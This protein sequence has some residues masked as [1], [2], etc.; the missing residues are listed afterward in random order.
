MVKVLDEG[1][2]LSEHTL[3]KCTADGALYNSHLVELT[4]KKDGK[5]Q[6]LA[7]EVA[8]TPPKPLEKRN[9]E[10]FGHYA[11]WFTKYSRKDARLL[12]SGA[13]R[14]ADACA[15]SDETRWV[16][17]QE[18]GQQ[19]RMGF[20]KYGWYCRVFLEE[21]GT[22]IANYFEPTG[23]KKADDAKK[24]AIAAKCG[25]KNMAFMNMYTMEVEP[26]VTF[27]DVKFAANKKKLWYLTEEEAEYVVFYIR[28]ESFK[29]Y[30]KEWVDW[31]KTY[32]LKADE[33]GLVVSTNC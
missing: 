25:E 7:V 12:S 16:V 21:D 1:A 5:T 2:D 31:V 33:C 30:A 8:H 24:A 22:I 32:S 20:R 3:L 13:V 4:R 11:E 23:D 18:K 28:C 6:L 9:E 26:D 10:D 27:E 19:M 17:F 15:K 14:S 29:I